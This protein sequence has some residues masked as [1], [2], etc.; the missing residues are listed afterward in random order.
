MDCATAKDR[1]VAYLD[2]ELPASL[3]ERIEAHLSECRA[4]TEELMA[5]RELDVSLGRLPGLPVPAH[6]TKE[7][8]RKA[9]ALGRGG[10][11]FPVWWQ[12]LGYAWRFAACSA[13][14]LGLLS[15][16]L[17]SK[18][19]FL[20]SGTTSSYPFFL[21]DSGQEPSLTTTYGAMIATDL[22]E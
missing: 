1:L 20:L 15:G 8:Y 12:G 22:G 5:I 21:A 19:V 6:F 10:E 2:G 9:K 13:V 11:S 17:V 16:G 14:L 7:T 4:C 18:S 3:C